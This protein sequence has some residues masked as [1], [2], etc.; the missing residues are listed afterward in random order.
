MSA[1]EKGSKMHTVGKNYTCYWA[2]YV[3]GMCLVTPRA[4][5]VPNAC[6]WNMCIEHNPSSDTPTKAIQTCYNKK[7]I[8]VSTSC[9]QAFARI[10]KLLPLL[11]NLV[12]GQSPVRCTCQHQE[13]GYKCKEQTGYGTR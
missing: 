11:E 4:C 13:D 6:L 5:S 2:G 8:S 12:K 9:T 1:I 3:V 10:P 7:E